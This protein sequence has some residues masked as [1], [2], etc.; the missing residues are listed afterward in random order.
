MKVGNLSMELKALS[1][2]ASLLAALLHLH[3]LCVTTFA[4]VGVATQIQRRTGGPS[5]LVKASTSESSILPTA[6]SISIDNEDD[7]E[8]P[9]SSSS[10]RVLLL[11]HLNINHEKGRHDVVKAFYFDFLGC[12]IDPRKYDNYLSG[13]K[14]VWANIGMHQ[15]HLPEGEPKAQVF[16]GMITILHSNLDVLMERYNRYLDGEKDDKLAPLQNTEFLVGMLDNEMMLV[17]DP[18]GNEFCILPSDDPIE[19]RAA[20]IG[21][22]PT[23]DGHVES[24]GLAM[25]DITVYVPHTANL[26]GISRFYEYV[27]GAPTLEELSSSESNSISIAMGERQTLTFQYHPDGM[28]AD[29]EVEHHEFRYHDE[30]NDGDSSSDQPFYPSNYG[31]HISLYVSNLSHAYKQAEKLNVLYV[32]R[33][34]E[35][36]AYTLDEAI[37]QCMFRVIDMIDPLDENKEVI[38]RLEHEVRSTTTRDGRKYKSCPLLDVSGVN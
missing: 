28:D 34:F 20:N 31:P 7:V 27:F 21:S 14:T 36:Q 33:R 13:K 11:D 1:P 16:Q 17:T 30:E 32:N 25:E 10:C 6:N 8:Q 23:L 4:F 35:R 26:D 5:V 38:L 18:W 37:D 9:S 12:S 15:F 29:D 2:S 22:Q 24:E 19:D 3:C